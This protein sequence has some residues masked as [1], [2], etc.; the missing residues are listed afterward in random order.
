M[1]RTSKRSLPSSHTGEAAES[2]SSRDLRARPSES[3]STSGDTK[4]TAL[5]AAL[6]D[7][8]LPAL[9]NR[10]RLL[11]APDGDLTWLPFEVLPTDDGRH[12]I[13]DCQIG[14]LG[15]EHDV[16]RFGAAS[17]GQPAEP[18]VAADPDFNLSGGQAQTQAVSETVGAAPRGRVSREQKPKTVFSLPRMFRV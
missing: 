6:F 16:L 4:G 15:A 8:L 2:H 9:D 3:V 17:S 13:D 1:G 14:Y 7:P 5:R 18:L 10:K 12:L 11:L